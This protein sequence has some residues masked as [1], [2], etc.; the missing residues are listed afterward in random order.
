VTAPG[1][2]G[3]YRKARKALLDVLGPE[4]IAR[5][6]RGSPLLDWAAIVVLP[7]LFVTGAM[8]LATWHLGLVWGL[9]FVLQ[10]FVIQ[11]FGYVVHDLFVH[12]RVGG[13]AGY[14]IGA[15]FELV[16]TFRRT[17]Y[18]LYHLD[19]HAH[20]NTPDDPE[21]YKQD[22]DCRWKRV[23]FLTLPGAILAMSRRLKPS[24]PISPHV[25][26]SALAPPDREAV[27][28]LRFERGLALLALGTA[29]LTALAWWQLVVFGYLLP[30]VLVTPIAS[31]LRVLLEHAE[32][33]DDNV[34]HCGV[35]YR[36]GPVSGPLFFW[37]A[38]D[39]HIV[40]HIYPAIPFYRIPEA[41][42]LMRPILV[43]H[44]AR[45]RSLGALL[46]G[47][48]VRNEAHRTVWSR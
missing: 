45:E 1:A 17:W 16:I 28:C 47:W 32:A 27:W 10:G 29:G 6:H 12:R 26:A 33:D 34:F 31:A 44:G 48:F 24:Q 39:C 22:L 30:L 18:A 13:G 25:A 41:L 11:A 7:A 35:F 46:H 20:M 21:A 36:T 23:L 14:Y 38:G 19:H 40:H 37:D 42:R 15:V 5:L 4:A 2:V 43:E 9:C 3:E 8:A